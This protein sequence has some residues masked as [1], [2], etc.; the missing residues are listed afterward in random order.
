[1]ENLTLVIPAKNEKYSLPRVLDEIKNYNCKKLIVLSKSDTETI[2]SIK[3]YKCRIIKQKYNGYGNALIEGINNVSTDF[4]CIFNADGSFD[5]KYLKIMLNKTN[6]NKGFVFASRYMKGGGST[7]DSILTFVGNII[8]TFIGKF[9]FQLKISDILFT[10][11]MGET[12][13]FKKLKLNNSDFRICV[14]IPLKVKI[15][16]FKYQS[17]GSFERKRLG[18]IKKVNEFLD[19]FLILLELIKN[20]LS[21]YAKN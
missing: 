18:G 5:P 15:N 1:M 17:I 21:P 16:N 20:Y 6:L 12:P 11:I 7:D 4:L 19:G 2:R 10:Y 8:F 9:F 14:E 13:K 3:N